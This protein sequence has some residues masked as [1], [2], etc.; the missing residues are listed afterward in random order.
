[1][2]A[3]TC[4]ERIKEEKNAVLLEPLF[5]A[6]VK[7]HLTGKDSY[8]RLVNKQNGQERILTG[9]ADTWLTPIWGHMAR[10]QLCLHSGGVRP[11]DVCN[12][13]YCQVV[14]PDYVET[15]PEGK[16]KA[17]YIDTQT[18]VKVQNRQRSGGWRGLT[19]GQQRLYDTGG[20]FVPAPYELILEA[21]VL[22]DIAGNQTLIS[23]SNAT[24]ATD[25]WRRW[26]AALVWWHGGVS[27]F[28]QMGAVAENPH[29]STPF[30]YLLY[31]KGGGQM[32]Y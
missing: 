21:T 13:W 27:G 7:D 24:G 28:E 3:S 15:A 1:M 17:V 4:E 31:N 29:S 12:A 16:K 25:A 23:G 6:V 32:F 30:E 10:Y 14:V 19:S 11:T 18:A 22:R 9:P 5:Y 8:L 2:I 20:V 26:L